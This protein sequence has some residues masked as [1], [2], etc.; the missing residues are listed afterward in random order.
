MKL[1]KQQEHQ[2]STTSIRS[3]AAHFVSDLT[4]V[5]LNPISDKPSSNFSPRSGDVSNEPRRNTQQCNQEEDVL[6][7]ADGPDT[8]SFTAFLYSFLSPG[9]SENE[10]EYSECN[11]NQ[12]VTR[13]RNDTS[14]PNVSKE[15]NG[16]KGLFSKGKQSLGKA[17]SQAARFS[18]YRSHASGKVNI[19]SKIDDMKETSSQFDTNDGV[20]VQNVIASFPSDKLPKMSEPSQLMTENTRSDL[21]V[22]LPVLSQGKKWVLLYSTWRHGICLSILYRRSNLC[23]GLSLLVMSCLQ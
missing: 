5:L 8:S 11:D 1:G 18:G 9:R 13:Y 19:E 7:L 10:S 12:V 4:T 23:P 20:P 15:N 17:L 3:K 6:V 16:K 14:S 2:R 21:Y 22:A